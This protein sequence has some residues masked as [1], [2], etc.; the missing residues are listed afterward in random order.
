MPKFVSLRQVLL[1]TLPFAVWA[2][3]PPA[4][5][6]PC[7]RPTPEAERLLAELAKAGEA[8]RPHTDHIHLAADAGGGRWLPRTSLG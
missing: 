1:L 5:S 6:N 3:E 7:K 2:A 4:W 8:W